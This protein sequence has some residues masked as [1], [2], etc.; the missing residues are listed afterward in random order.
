[1]NQIIEDVDAKIKELQTDID[2]L[3]LV[4]VELL[5]SLEFFK[6]LALVLQDIIYV[7]ISEASNETKQKIVEHISALKYCYAYGDTYQGNRQPING[8]QNLDNFCQIVIKY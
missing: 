8:V 5:K 1:M 2:N 6:E 4:K 3:K 7:D